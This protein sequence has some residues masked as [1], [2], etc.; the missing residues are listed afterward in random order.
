[1]LRIF[2]VIQLL[3]FETGSGDVAPHCLSWLTPASLGSLSNNYSRKYLPRVY[4][5]CGVTYLRLLQF[6]LDMLDVKRSSEM[7]I[8]AGPYSSSVKILLL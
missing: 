4:A 2:G 1:M 3:R 8:V 6:N 5:L 7:K